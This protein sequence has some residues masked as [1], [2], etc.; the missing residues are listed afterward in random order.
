[1]Y[2]GQSHRYLF[3]CLSQSSSTRMAKTLLGATLALCLLVAQVE[4]SPNSWTSIGLLEDMPVVSNNSNVF[5]I[6]AARGLLYML[7]TESNY[8]TLISIDPASG[9]CTRLDAAAGVTGDP[10][11]AKFGGSGFDAWDDKLYVFGGVVGVMDGSS[12]YSNDLHEFDP[13]TRAWEQLDSAAGVTGIAPSARGDMGFSANNGSL[14]VTFGYGPDHWKYDAFSYKIS[15]KTWSELSSFHY[16][17]LFP[18]QTVLGDTLYVFGGNRTGTSAENKLFALQVSDPA[19]QWTTVTVQGDVLVGRENPVLVTVGTKLVFFGG[20]AGDGVISDRREFNDLYL[21]RPHEIAWAQVSDTAGQ[22]PLLSDHV[23]HSGS[24]A[25]VI[26]CSMYVFGGFA[27]SGETDKY[28]TGLFRYDV[29]SEGPNE[30]KCPPRLTG[31][32]GG[33]CL[34]CVAGM[35]KIATGDASSSS[36]SSCPIHSH[37]LPASDKIT[38]CTCNAGYF[39]P[40][41]ASVSCSDGCPCSVSSGTTSGTFFL[42]VSSNYGDNANCRWLITANN[43]ISLSFSSF[44]TKQNSVFVTLN[45]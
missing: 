27:T 21:Y 43:E 26:G 34:Q 28:S 6:A 11:F 9:V 15:T 23:D 32:N 31:P 14:F 1:M 2:Y 10:P 39:L 22:A 5:G 38:D 19:A 20:S 25:T 17:I 16:G 45:R 12:I 4:A 13:A 36:C 42:D 35:Y 7:R 18:V 29:E 41:S 8:A 30:C 24:R 37:S 44:N 40:G 3:K 33:P